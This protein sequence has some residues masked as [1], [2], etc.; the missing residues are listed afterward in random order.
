MA[1]GEEHGWSLAHGEFL[2]SL[3]F[4]YIATA[5]P[6]SPVDQHVRL[7]VTSITSVT[8]PWGSPPE[9]IHYIE[10]QIRNVGTVTVTAYNLSVTEIQA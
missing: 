6:F 10:I 8:R 4:T 9:Q 2:E 1:P 5:H 7:S 3:S